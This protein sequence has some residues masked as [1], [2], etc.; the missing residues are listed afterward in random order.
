MIS[1]LYGETLKEEE[2]SRCREV[3]RLHEKFS[4]QLDDYIVLREA[5][6]TKKKLH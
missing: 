6:E 1:E 2:V 4:K 5:Q 3:L